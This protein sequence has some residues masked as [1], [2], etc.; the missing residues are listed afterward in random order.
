ME[1]VFEPD[2]YP[3]LNLDVESP[4]RIGYNKYN[5]FNLRDDERMSFHNYN[6][7]FNSICDEINE[8]IARYHGIKSFQDGD[9]TNLMTTNVIILHIC[10]VMNIIMSMKSNTIPDLYLKTGLFDHLD[11]TLYRQLNFS[12]VSQKNMK[13]FV[14]HIDY[15]YMSYA[16]FGNTSFVPIRTTVILDS[17]IFV[18]SSYITNNDHFKNHQFGKLQEFNEYQDKMVTKIVYRS[19]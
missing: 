10:D 12:F 14:R 17:P 9:D 3:K 4:E 5:M 16:Y 7:K 18:E 13:L 2:T 11:D 15:F 6:L 8:N 1:Y 19:I